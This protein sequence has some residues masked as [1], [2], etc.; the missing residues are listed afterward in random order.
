MGARKLKSK[1]FLK[2]PS[3]GKVTVTSFLS[4]KSSYKIEPF[5]CSTLENSRTLS[6]INPAELLAIQMHTRGGSQGLILT[7]FA[8]YNTA[9]CVIPHT[10]LGRRA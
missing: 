5:F 6:A 3:I 1:R 4:S 2:N 10:E 8:S 7:E 9:F